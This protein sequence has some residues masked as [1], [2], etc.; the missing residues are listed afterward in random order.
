MTTQ[1][2]TFWQVITAQLAAVADNADTFD[3]VKA[4][5]DNTHGCPDPY[6]T[7]HTDRPNHA[8]FYGS[9]GDDTLNEALSESGWTLSWAEANYYW[10]CT[11]PVTGEILTYIEGD[12]YRGA[13]S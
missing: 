5:L 6:L 13:H 8:Q 12:V 1:T 3:K 10:E 9:G 4:A 7:G 2:L 11:H